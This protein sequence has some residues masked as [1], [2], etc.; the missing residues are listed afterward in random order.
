MPYY[1]YVLYR[2][3]TVQSRDYVKVQYHHMGDVILQYVYLQFN[4]EDIWL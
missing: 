3:Y 2:L 4:V 1:V